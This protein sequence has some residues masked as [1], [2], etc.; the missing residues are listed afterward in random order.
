VRCWRGRNR[1]LAPYVGKPVEW[2]CGFR[3]PVP[4]NENGLH[5]FL[6]GLCASPAWTASEIREVE[7][8]IR[9]LLRL[10]P[11][12]PDTIQFQTAVVPPD[13]EAKGTG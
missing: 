9:R 10:G 2:L 11:E 13:S 6:E 7:R 8:E 1:R 4:T 12:E 5:R 3:S